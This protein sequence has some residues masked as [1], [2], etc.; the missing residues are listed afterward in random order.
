MIAGPIPSD[1]F[2]VFFFEKIYFI[3]FASYGDFSLKILSVCNQR[4]KQNVPEKPMPPPTTPPTT[5][6][7]ATVDH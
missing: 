1:T 5:A 3:F 4:D 2:P 7:H 6:V